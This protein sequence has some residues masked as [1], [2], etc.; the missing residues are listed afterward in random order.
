M[1]K[2]PIAIMIF[3]SLAL[4]CSPSSNKNITTP[5]VPIA[6]F[7][8]ITANTWTIQSIVFKKATD[9]VTDSA[10][11]TSSDSLGGSR[12][13]FKINSYINPSYQFYDQNNSSWIGPKNDTTLFRYGNGA[14]S[15]DAYWN[16]TYTTI[17]TAIP[18]SLLFVQAD[19]SG[20]P[21]NP[22]FSGAIVNL[23]SS[24]LQFIYKDVSILNKTT[25][26]Y[27]TLTKLISMVPAK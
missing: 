18:D 6:A 25:N 14:W 16:Q 17:P 1:K 20:N 9:G 21:I 8:F 24:R 4:A 11:Y 12:I 23:D 26:Q 10:A 3:M 27:D 22:V 13:I 2:I 19:A 15:F 5:V 7:N